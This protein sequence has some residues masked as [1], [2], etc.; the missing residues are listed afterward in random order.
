MATTNSKGPDAR[1]EALLKEFEESLAVLS[2]ARYSRN[3][4]MDGS[5]LDA[6]FEGG[7]EALKKLRSS[8]RWPRRT[9]NSLTR[10][11]TEIGWAWSR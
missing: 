9:I 2:A 3:G 7:I 1:T 11:A 6:A 8:K 4:R 5:R 10:Q